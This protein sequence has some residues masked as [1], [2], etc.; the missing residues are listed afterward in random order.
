MASDSESSFYVDVWVH[1]ARFHSPEKDS[2]IV[3]SEWIQSLVV[4]NKIVYFGTLV[5]VGQCAKIGYLLLFSAIFSWRAIARQYYILM[6]DFAGHKYSWLAIARQ[7]KLH[8]TRCEW[9]QFHK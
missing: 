3:G 8:L 1:L 6:S 9:M 7:K 4:R 2:Q 5:Y